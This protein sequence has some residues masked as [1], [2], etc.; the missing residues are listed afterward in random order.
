[1][2]NDD[3]KA[4]KE[5]VY[6]ILTIVV[7]KFWAFDGF[8]EG[9]KV[10]AIGFAMLTF[11]A[12]VL[13]SFSIPLGGSLCKRALVALMCV[14]LVTFFTLCPSCI[15]KGKVM[16]L[17]LYCLFLGCLLASSLMDAPEENKS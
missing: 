9:L 1:M 10:D 16:S 5:L 8:L 2:G 4:L 17:V 11:M 13:G 12:F 15:S 7:V 14:T 3:N 6:L